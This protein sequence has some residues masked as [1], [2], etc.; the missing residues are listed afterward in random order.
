MHGKHISQTSNCIYLY[1]I[2]GK[3]PVFFF[4]STGTVFA[5]GRLQQRT[6]TVNA[7]H[8]MQGTGLRQFYRC[9]I[10][11]DDVRR[12]LQTQMNW[13]ELKWTC[14]FSSVPLGAVHTVS[15]ITAVRVP[16]WPYF[17]SREADMKSRQGVGRTDAACVAAFEVNLR[18]KTPPTGNSNGSRT[19]GQWL[20]EPVDQTTGNVQTDLSWN[21]P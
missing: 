2:L 5:M 15:Y 10:T 3:C 8:A 9:S 1:I 18:V 13:S 19:V 17:A 6:A 20:E 12:L 21:G 11:G 16:E 7:H 4:V 14:Q